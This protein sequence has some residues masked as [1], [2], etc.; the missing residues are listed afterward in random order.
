MQRR[1]FLRAGLGA[2]AA[3]ALPLVA[4]AEEQ[5]YLPVVGHN[6]ALGQ[7]WVPEVPLREAIWYEP[8]F[9]G[10]ASN[11]LILNEGDVAESRSGSFLFSAPD[12]FLRFKWSL[13]YVVPMPPVY[14]VKRIIAEIYQGPY[15]GAPR[16]FRAEVSARYYWPIEAHLPLNNPGPFSAV[17]TVVIAPC[18]ATDLPPMDQLPYH[19]FER[20][21]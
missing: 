19:R 9:G 13:H 10:D 1:R 3:L 16:F 12:G 5:V 20:W 15:L 4:R 17:I 11:Q 6:T 14:Q 8:T 7:D 21:A 18:N 2:A